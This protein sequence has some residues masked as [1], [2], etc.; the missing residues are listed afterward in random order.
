MLIT[1]AVSP[2]IAFMSPTALP[3]CCQKFRTLVAMPALSQKLMLW[4]K[5][6]KRAIIAPKGTSWCRDR[7]I[8]TLLLAKSE[9][10]LKRGRKHSC[11]MR[12]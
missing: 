8:N 6:Q 12:M 2:S 10:P 9:L 3:L 4:P 7:K 1:A 5:T 11:A